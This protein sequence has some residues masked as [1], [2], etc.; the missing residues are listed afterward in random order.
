MI[1]E[2]LKKGV[3]GGMTG[4]FWLQIVG[5]SRYVVS[6]QSLGGQRASRALLLVVVCLLAFYI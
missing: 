1:Y 6:A 3:L 5:I 2:Q 4:L